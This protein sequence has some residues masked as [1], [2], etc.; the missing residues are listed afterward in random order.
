MKEAAIAASPW[1]RIE[2]GL[3]EVRKVNWLASLATF[4]RKM[5][6]FD[7]RRPVGR[8]KNTAGGGRR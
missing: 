7:V 5:T 2:T 6:F 8:Q 3:I 4:W 1:S